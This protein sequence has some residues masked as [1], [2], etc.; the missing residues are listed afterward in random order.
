MAHVKSA[1]FGLALLAILFACSPLRVYPAFYDADGNG[2]N[3]YY[4]A[5]GHPVESGG[6]SEGATP[7]DHGPHLFVDENGDGV[8]DRAQDGSPTWHGPGY[9]DDNNDG[10]PDDWDYY[11]DN[12]GATN[13]MLYIDKSD[14]GINDWVQPSGH[15][16]HN[17]HF[18]DEN[19]DGVCDKAQ[20]GTAKVWHGPNYKDKNNNGICDHWEEGELGYH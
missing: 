13:G 12:Y 2:I 6:T 9:R 3:D 5:R 4:E 16:G 1:G 17:H 15:D 11:H 18:V 7:D 8:C 20:D 10:M 14:D 19:N